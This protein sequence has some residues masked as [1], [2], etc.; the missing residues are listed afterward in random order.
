MT[1]SHS[2]NISFLDHLQDNNWIDNLVRQLAYA[3]HNDSELS[4]KEIQQEFNRPGPSLKLLK[5]RG[6]SPEAL[7]MDL[8]TYLTVRWFARE[9]CAENRETETEHPCAIM[10]WP[11]LAITDETDL[12]QLRRFVGL[13]CYLHPELP[14]TEIMDQSLF[15]I[16]RA[17]LVDGALKT[18]PFLEQHDVERILEEHHKFSKHYPE[19]VK[20][21]KKS[22]QMS[23]HQNFDD[24]VHEQWRVN[25]NGH[26]RAVLTLLEQRAKKGDKTIAMSHRLLDIIAGEKSTLIKEMGKT[27]SKTTDQISS[28]LRLDFKALFKAFEAS[29]FDPGDYQYTTF[30]HTFGAH[31]ASK[32]PESG[33][34]DL[35]VVE[36]LLKIFESQEYDNGVRA[37]VAFALGTMQYTS[38]EA[39]MAAAK[40]IYGYLDSPLGVPDML[41]A[42]GQ[43]PRFRLEA[44]LALAKIGYLEIEGNDI[45]ELIICNYGNL[46]K[47]PEARLTAV[48]ALGIFGT[49]ASTPMA[50]RKKILKTLSWFIGDP[51]NTVVAKGAYLWHDKVHRMAYP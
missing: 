8:K 18:V 38:A 6:M 17:E 35:N 23:D 26:Q 10:P 3:D 19:P 48:W 42:E 50:D 1:E 43:I 20:D 46:S 31:V 9:E 2:L 44:V 29:A 34:A 25:P 33:L 32:L 37:A 15:F 49:H 13:I 45:L 40:G 12:A 24:L 22:S 14:A 47:H 16:G 27:L 21:P 7:F 51:L 11:A 28:I 41:N 4:L 39:R 5:D 30:N 36:K